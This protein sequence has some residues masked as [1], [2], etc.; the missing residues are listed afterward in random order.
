MVFDKMTLSILDSYSDNT[1]VYVSL[2]F[3]DKIITEWRCYIHYNKII[4]IKNYSG[5]FDILPDLKWAEIYLKEE[6]D[7]VSY[8][9]NK[10]NKFPIAFTMDLGVLENGKTVIIEYND[11]WAIGNY[12]INN[13]D[14]YKLLR[15]RYFEI[16]KY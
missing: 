10:L 5:R 11:M 1:H 8:E 4:D 9:F 15:E 16:V 14:Y 3:D 6:T 7:N 2:P 13:Y 12:G